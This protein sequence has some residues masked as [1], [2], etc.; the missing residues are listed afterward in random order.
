MFCQLVTGKRLTVTK[1][2][3]PYVPAL[4]TEIYIETS[5]YRKTYGTDQTERRF[6]TLRGTLRLLPAEYIPNLLPWRI[7]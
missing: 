1:G 5:W 3:N 6:P 2:I 7:L 4:V